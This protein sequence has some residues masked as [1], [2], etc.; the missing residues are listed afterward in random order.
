MAKSKI[1]LGFLAGAAAGA[2]VYAFLR[3]DTGKKVAQ[4]LKDTAGKWQKEMQ[5]MLK[6]GKQMADDFGKET[7]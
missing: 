6:K 7:A 1:L 2:A 3:S 5:D 4:D